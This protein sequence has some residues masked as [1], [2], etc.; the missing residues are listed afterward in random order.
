MLS[1]VFGVHNTLVNNVVFPSEN[2]SLDLKRVQCFLNFFSF[3]NHLILLSLPPSLK[4]CNILKYIQV[5]ISI[6]MTNSWSSSVAVLK[7]YLWINFFLIFCV[8]KCEAYVMKFF[9]IL[10][11][12]GYPKTF[13]MK[14]NFYW[15][16]WQ[17]M[18]M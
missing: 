15:K 13:F 10:K 2:L 17:T 7:G 6:L 11:I 1:Q 8:T 12:S 3:K 18:V 9:S 5:S 4:S 16:D 14:H